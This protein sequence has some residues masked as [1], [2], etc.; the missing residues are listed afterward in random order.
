MKNW[1]LCP[2]TPGVYRILAPMRWLDTP[3]RGDTS[4]R[5]LR[6]PVLSQQE[7]ELALTITFNRPRRTGRSLRMSP[8]SPV[9]KVDHH[10]KHRNN[11]VWSLSTVFNNYFQITRG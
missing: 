2:Q 5:S 8:A 11:M 9:S 1:G 4:T 7:T 6:D 10:F 3:L